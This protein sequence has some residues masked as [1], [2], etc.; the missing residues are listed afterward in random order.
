MHKKNW[1]KQ[2]NYWKALADKQALRRK[3]R[4]RNKVKKNELER[5]K[6]TD[7]SERVVLK[8]NKIIQFLVIL[9]KKSAEPSELHKY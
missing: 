6:F 3:S 8:E 7:L 9:A 5:R 1:N 2:I 4:G